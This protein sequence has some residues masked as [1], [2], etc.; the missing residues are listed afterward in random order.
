MKEVENATVWQ[1][2]HLPKPRNFGAVAWTLDMIWISFGTELHN[3]RSLGSYDSLCNLICNLRVRNLLDVELGRVV[4]RW[5]WQAD[6]V[7][8]FLSFLNVS[9]KDDSPCVHENHVC[10][11]MEDV[12]CWLMNGKQHDSWCRDVLIEKLG[13][14]NVAGKLPQR[15][16]DFKGTEAVQSRCG[17]VAE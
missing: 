2:E 16:H 12:G 6:A 1:Q 14:T 10:E 3:L 13:F 17:L 9:M 8:H 4:E 11:E 15:V 5:A 7:E